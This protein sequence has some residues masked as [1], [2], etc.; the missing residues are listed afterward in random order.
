FRS[1]F[2]EKFENAKNPTVRVKEGPDPGKKIRSKTRDTLFLIVELVI[3]IF[4]L[5]SEC[6]EKFENAKNPTVRVKEGP[7]PGKKI[8]SKTRDTLF[9]IVELVITIFSL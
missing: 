2:F 9:L 7:D 4:S 3:T 8:R 1:E 5:R 6:F